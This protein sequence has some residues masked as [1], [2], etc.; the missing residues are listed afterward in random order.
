MSFL[1]K[2]LAGGVALTWSSMK[3]GEIKGLSHGGPEKHQ[4]EMDSHGENSLDCFEIH[5]M[6]V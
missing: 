6:S 4:S 2:D 3:S 5:E 1:N